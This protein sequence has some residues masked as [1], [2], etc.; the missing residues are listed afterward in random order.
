VHLDEPFDQMQANA[1]TA[2]G[3]VASIDLREH[4]ED[5]RQLLGRYAP[6]RYR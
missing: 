2:V 1:Q 4:L 5:A 6:C 3:P